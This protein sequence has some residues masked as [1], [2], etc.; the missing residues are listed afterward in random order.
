MYSWYLYKKNQLKC[1][2]YTI[3][4]TMSAILHNFI[5][6]LILELMAISYKY[7]VNNDFKKKMQLLLK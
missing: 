5:T 3:C 2:F 1:Y 4:E 7:L 6:T